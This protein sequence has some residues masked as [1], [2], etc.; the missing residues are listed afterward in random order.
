MKETYENENE[1]TILDSTTST[2]VSSGISLEDFKSFYYLIN[3]KPDR[4]TK[5]YKSGRIVA[6]T[7]IIELNDLIQEK[8]NLSDTI[9]SQ[10]TVIVTLSNNRTLDFG[11][12]E[13]FISEKWHTSAI[14][15]TINITWDFSV[16]LPSYKFPQRHTVHLRIGSKLKPKDMFELVMNQD[17]DQF[18]NAFAHAIC[19][20]DFI[21]PVISNELFLII[22]NWHESLP[23]NFFNYKWQLSL[24]NYSKKIEYIIMFLVLVAGSTILFW[25]SKI[26]LNTIF[27]EKFDKIFLSRIFGGL[28]ASSLLYFIIYE[29]GTF[30]AKKST[31]YIQKLKPFSLFKF[32]NGDENANEENKK[33]NSEV[34]KSFGIKVFITIV[35]NVLAFSSERIF[36]FLSNLF[37]K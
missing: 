19:S 8:L 13:Q 3:A 10:V 30:W 4:E 21:N 37:T 36:D 18:L 31:R 1:V 35:F 20:I 6:L 14:T 16:K 15:K 11:S 29:G 5:Y 27:T 32:T 7:N 33:K 22:E 28:L 25:L 2:A 17:D 26:Y 23:K 34:L 9:T 12:W 24:I